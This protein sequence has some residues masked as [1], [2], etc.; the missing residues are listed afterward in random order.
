MKRIFIFTLI[1]SFL[2]GVFS[3]APPPTESAKSYSKSEI[4]DMMRDIQTLNLINGLN[5]SQDQMQKL[6]PVAREVK[7]RQDK[8]QATFDRKNNE[9]Y[10]VLKEMKSQLMSKSDVTNDL[11]KRYHNAEGEIK[12]QRVEFNERMKV[13]N[14]EISGILNDNQKVVLKEYQPCIVPV[15]S[16]ANP[17]RIGQ[18]A[19]G[20]RFQRLF[21]RIRRIPED[22][23]PQ[24]KERILARTKEKIK[25]HIRDDKEREAA[26]K[27]LS[28]AMDKA[29]S[30]SDEEFEMKKGEIASNIKPERK[31]SRN[32]EQK[33]IDRFLLNP[34]LVSILEHKMRMASR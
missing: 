3:L 30:L 19:G 4:R 1:V 16:I 6:L 34:N 25:M 29:R 20:E 22:R 21:S 5:L 26:L 11:K 9:I 33:F 12:K 7:Q 17:E 18:A 10:S 13:L 32:I 8:I 31:K 28:E 14:K 24:A 27:N 2:I 23:Y 15:K